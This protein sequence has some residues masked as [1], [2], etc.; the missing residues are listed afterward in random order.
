MK[1]A[2]TKNLKSLVKNTKEV[3]LLT[4]MKIN[5]LFLRA[6]YRDYYDLYVINKKVYSIKEMF[7]IGKKYIPE[8]NQKLFQMAMTYTND[9]TEDHIKHLKP[10]YKITTQAI[11]KHFENEIKKWLKT[12]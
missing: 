7:N 1:T 3:E 8:I 6:K 9:I 4:A 11:S 2:D 12:K 5:T 10:E